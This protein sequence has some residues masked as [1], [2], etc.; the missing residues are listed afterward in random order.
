[1]R[2]NRI[3]RRLIGLLVAL[4]ICLGP[5]ALRAQTLDSAT[6]ANAAKLSRLLK[7]TGLTY[8]THSG[9]T[10]SV[11][12]Q[13]KNIGKVRVITSVGS[14]VVVT[15]AI[16]AKKAAIQ[17]TLQ[18]LDTLAS[19]N[20]EYDYAKIGLDKDGDLFVRI[21]TPSRLIDA[22]ELKSAIDQ[23]ANASDEV[24]ARVSGSIKH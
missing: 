12:L 23:V 21:D 6:A 22:K 17:K 3:L 16:L 18:L 15:F 14:D 2:P 8:N 20:H 1:V 7:E 9:T 19:A 13:R 11:D 4:S 5:A 24:F 10:W